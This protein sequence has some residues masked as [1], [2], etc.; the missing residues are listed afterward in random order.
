MQLKEYQ[1]ENYFLRIPRMHLISFKYLIP[2]N[3]NKLF[4]KLS[5]ESNDVTHVIFT[6]EDIN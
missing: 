2:E 1:R 5:L 4:V 6:L 3:R